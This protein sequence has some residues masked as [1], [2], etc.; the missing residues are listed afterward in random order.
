VTPREELRRLLAL[1]AW[2]YADAIKA[3]RLV[4]EIFGQQQELLQEWLGVGGDKC[5]PVTAQDEDTSGW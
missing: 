3:E 4:R 2:S 1:P 5:V